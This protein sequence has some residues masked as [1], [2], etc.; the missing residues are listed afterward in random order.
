[1]NESQRVWMDELNEARVDWG[2]VQLVAVA[3]PALAI[4]YS[5]VAA[6]VALARVR[7]AFK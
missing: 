5:V 1:M 3:V 4:A 2:T 7:R 6:K